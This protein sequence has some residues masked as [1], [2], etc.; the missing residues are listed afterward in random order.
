M[1]NTANSLTQLA[2]ETLLAM[3][4]RREL[5]PGEHLVERQLCEE[6]EVSRT[7]L[8]A[9][10]R[11]LAAQGLVVENRNRGCFIP[12]RDVRE[13]S[14]MNEARQALE[15][16]AARLWTLRGQPEHLGELR[17]TAM[18]AHDAALDGAVSRYYD[19]DFSFHRL[20]LRHCDNDYIAHYSGA[21][22]LILNSFINAPFLE[23]ISPRKWEDECSLGSIVEA[24]EAR[25]GDRA[26]AAARLHIGH[27]GERLLEL[28]EVQLPYVPAEESSQAAG[29]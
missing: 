10:L 23:S 3:I 11:T 1:P 7:P 20:L 9:A 15:G 25:D 12:K 8:R 28:M 13:I 24:I 2:Y 21:E 27:A 19:R 6:L 18:Q 14:Q 4:A 29:S 17:E 5:R 16:M 22:A 26:E